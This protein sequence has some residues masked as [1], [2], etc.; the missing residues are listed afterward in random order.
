MKGDSRKMNGN[1]DVIG[2]AKVQKC[3]GLFAKKKNSCK[4]Q[5][6]R[7]RILDQLNTVSTNVLLLYPLK[8]SE[9][10]MFSWGVAVEHW[11]KDKNKTKGFDL[12]KITY[13]GRFL[14]CWSL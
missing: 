12:S 8:T 2:N 3:K 13:K 10:S 6:S 1:S 11:F 4:T 14:C 5:Y 9:T 7:L